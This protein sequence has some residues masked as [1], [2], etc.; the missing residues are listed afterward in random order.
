MAPLAAP[1]TMGKRRSISA[2]CSV[3]KHLSRM[4]C[5]IPEA[6]PETGLTSFSIV[7][8]EVDFVPS[9]RLMDKVGWGFDFGN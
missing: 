5:Y 8:G 1:I 6:V 7:M 2:E 9:A 4:I 3:P